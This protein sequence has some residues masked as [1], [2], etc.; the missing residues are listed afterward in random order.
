VLAQ[1]AGVDGEVVDALLRLLLD[2]A[3]DDV[4]GQVLDPPADDHAVDGHGADRHRRVVDDRLPARR[5]RAAGGQ[6]HDRVRAEALRPASFSTSSSVVLDTGDA[7]MLALI[8]VVIMRPMPVGSRRLG[9][10]SPRRASGSSSTWARCA[11]V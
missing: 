7:P 9:A 6:V 11:T 3:Q 8:L 10:R 1:D 5:Q 2:L 4:V